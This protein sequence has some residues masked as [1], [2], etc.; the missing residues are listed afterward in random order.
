MAVDR[1]LAIAR[2]FGLAYRCFNKTTTVIVIIVL[3][4]SSLLMFSPILMVY[5]L[6]VDYYQI[7]PNE[8]ISAAI[9]WEFWSNLSIPQDTMGIIW[10]IFMFALPGK[11]VNI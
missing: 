9:C 4:F 1:Y 2:P 6:H 11:Y 10:F 8:T 7:G 5:Q 3:W